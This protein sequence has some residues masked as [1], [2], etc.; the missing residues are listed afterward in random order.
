[1]FQGPAPLQPDALLG[2]FI[3]QEESVLRR[4]AQTLDLSQLLPQGGGRVHHS[5]LGR[6]WVRGD[7]FKPVRSFLMLTAWQLIKL[8]LVVVVLI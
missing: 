5:R 8:D 4:G 6:E 2:V 3:S 1:M 7:T